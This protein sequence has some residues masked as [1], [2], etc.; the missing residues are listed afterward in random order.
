MQL[1]NHNLVM[2]VI[3]TASNRV[4]NEHQSYIGKDFEGAVVICCEVLSPNSLIE[5]QENHENLRQDSRQSGRDPNTVPPEYKDRMLSLHSPLRIIYSYCSLYQ[6]LWPLCHVNTNAFWN[7]S[8]MLP[9]MS[10]NNTEEVGL[11]VIL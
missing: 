5:A 6:D 10:R 9:S 8:F 3:H 11:E 1:A 7:V 2:Y 4:E